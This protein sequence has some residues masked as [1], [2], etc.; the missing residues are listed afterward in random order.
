[1]IPVKTIF[2]LLPW[3][4]LAIMGGWLY[5]QYGTEMGKT[6]KTTVT[7]HTILQRVETLGK[8]ELVKYNFKEITQL[9]ESLAEFV[10]IKFF[11]SNIVLISKGEAVGCI[12]LTKITATD[13]TD[14]GDTVYVSLPPPEICYFKLAMDDTQIFSLRT[15]TFSDDREFIGKAYK[16][17]EL[18]IKE[19]ALSSGILEQVKNNAVL[20]LKPLL[21]EIT[22]KP[23]VLRYQ[24]PP[25]KIELEKY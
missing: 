22:D 8:L 21:E 13:I 23:V 9:N 10:G 2:K 14:Q 25:E 18:E 19:A 20:V 3:L 1:M 24:M 17:A 11:E 6:P 16:I 12:D 5:L 7:N 15:A 4:L